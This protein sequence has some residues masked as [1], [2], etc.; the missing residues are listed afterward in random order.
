MVMVGRRRRHSSWSKSPENGKCACVV[1][2]GWM[3]VGGGWQKILDVE[4]LL[5]LSIFRSQYDVP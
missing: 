5:P 4:F 1:G 3:M 2:G